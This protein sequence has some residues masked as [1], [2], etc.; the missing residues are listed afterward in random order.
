[1]LGNWAWSLASVHR[2]SRRTLC[3]WAQ[4]LI[5]TRLQV[6]LD[7][8]GP[9]EMNDHKKWTAK[10]WCR[11]WDIEHIV[12]FSPDKSFKMCNMYYKLWYII[13]IA[14]YI[15]VHAYASALCIPQSPF[16]PD[17][18]WLVVRIHPWLSPWKKRGHGR[19]WGALR[20]Q[21]STWKILDIFI[22]FCQFLLM[23]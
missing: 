5:A 1:M 6:A 7:W 17:Q 10:C 13:Y 15:Y 8:E 23:F 3:K 18:W 11:P 22:E 19:S 20:K 4:S 16:P 9:V 2:W 14:I 12:F 21:C